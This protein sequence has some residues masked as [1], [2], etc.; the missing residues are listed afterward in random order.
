MHTVTQEGAMHVAT[1]TVH[2]RDPQQAL[3]FWTNKVG[4]VSYPPEAIGMSRECSVVGPSASGPAIIIC[5][6]LGKQGASRDASPLSII[7]YC[8]NVRTVAALMKSRGVQFLRDS[9]S[10]DVFVDPEGNRYGLKEYPQSR[11]R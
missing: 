7:F 8:H 1:V 5:A 2:V 3:D 11:Y 6:D 10:I 4:Y 9:A